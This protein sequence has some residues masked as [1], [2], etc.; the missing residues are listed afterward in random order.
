MIESTGTQWISATDELV[1]MNAASVRRFFDMVE[2]HQVNAS[3][4]GL[5][6]IGP[7]TTAEIERYTEQ[8]VIESDKPELDGLIR[9]IINN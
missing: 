3:G 2:L 1:F 4:Y 5:Y 6:S 7:K 8:P 9:V